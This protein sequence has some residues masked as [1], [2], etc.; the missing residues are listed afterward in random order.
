MDARQSATAQH[1]RGQHGRGPVEPVRRLRPAAS[2]VIGAAALWGSTGPIAALYPPPSSLAVAAWRLIIGALALVAAVCASRRRWTPWRRAD[3]PTAVGG[4]LAVAAYSALYFPAIQ[5]SGAATATVV[6]IG[7]APL[8]SATAHALRGGG[9][10]RR[11]LA[12]TTLAVA[13]MCLVVLPRSHDSASWLGVLLATLAAATYPWQDHTIE[14]L[15][16]RHGPIPTVA[17]L[18]CGAA[19]VSLLTGIR[20]IGAVTATPQAIIGVVY[21]GLFTTAIAYSS[22]AYGVPRVGAPTAVS[23]SL[24][25]PVAATALAALITHQLP[26]VVQV[27]GTAMT[28]AALG[29]LGHSLPN[30][31][32]TDQIKHPRTSRGR[33]APADVADTTVTW[34][35][36]SAKNAA[37]LGTEH[38]RT[39]YCVRFGRQPCP[40]PRRERGTRRRQFT[41]SWRCP[42]WCPTFV[43][44]AKNLAGRRSGGEH[45]VRAV[46][47]AAGLGVHDGRFGLDAGAGVDQHHAAR[48]RCQASIAPGGK[49]D[50]D[51]PKR[52]TQV[53]EHVFEAGRAGLV[54]AA[55]QQPVGDQPFEPASQQAGRD[56]QVVLELFEAAVAVER[57]MHDQQRPPLTDQSQRRRQRTLAVFQPD[58]VRHLP[59]P[60]VTAN[61]EVSSFNFSSN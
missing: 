16:P 46:D 4:A 9:V 50:D 11:W 44:V 13:G 33:H 56:P 3:V 58:P 47:P 21:L 54:L 55:L 53:G 12:G 57:V 27:A 34:L 23:L 36:H 60:R 52:A 48:L 29:W 24:L 19:L 61:F 51:R 49:H 26:T 1:G 59:A 8:L 18:F 20:G 5:L 28:L 42:G 17:V 40:R 22:F 43:P 38:D 10:D 32:P 31:T 37:P 39:S 15:S 41:S 7:A 14:R 30:R 2:A 35:P 6:S 25:E 45:E